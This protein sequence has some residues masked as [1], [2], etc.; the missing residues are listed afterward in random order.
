MNV[1]VIIADAVVFLLALLLLLSMVFILMNAFSLHRQR[2]YQNRRTALNQ[3]ITDYLDKKVSAKAASQEIGGDKDL[4]LG[5]VSQIAQ[6]ADISRRAQLIQFFEDVDLAGIP[7]QQLK[8][9]AS[10]DFV[11]RQRAAI[12]LPYISRPERITQPLID[13]LK[14][15]TL[16]VR[17]ASARSLGVLQCSSAIPAII[18]NL[19]LP[20]NWPIQRVVEVIQQM[21]PGSIENLIAYLDSPV[22]TDAGRI[23]AIS[24]LGMQK[25]SRAIPAIKEV[26]S[27]ASLEVRIQCAKALGNIADK[28][29]TETLRTAMKDDSWELRSACATALGLLKDELAVESL[30][31]G[32][33]DKNWW[34]RFNSANALHAI[35][36]PGIEALKSCLQDDD[37]FARDVSRLVLDEKGTAL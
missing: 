28:Q 17:L 6:G 13:A 2:R 29:A 30:C 27:K 1:F 11:L 4:L 15:E 9:L 34:V 20:S 35:G 33:K 22:V 31:L 23:V 36:G 10:K 14:D 8:N 24:V 25:D 26:L 21:G 3:S 16:D 19:A 32:L 12:F 5:V 7:Q 37:Q 18:E